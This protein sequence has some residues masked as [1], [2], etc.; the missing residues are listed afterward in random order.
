MEK[1]K[2]LRR[3]PAVHELV[4]ACSGEEEGYPAQLLAG[5]ARE[6]LAHWRKIVL[7]KGE[8]PPDLE[9]LAEA[10]RARIREKFRPSLRPVVNATGVVLHTN[11]G[12]APLSP[13]AIAALE[14]VARG[15]CNLEIELETGGRGS[16]Y[17]HVEKLLTALTGA[18]AALVVNNN[19]AAVL[20]AL[21]T[22]ARGREVVV[23]RGELIEIGGSF[24]I[25]EV[26]AQSGARLREVGTTNKT[27]PRDYER[28]IGPETALL[29]KV[30]PSNYRILGFTREVSRGEL[31][32]LGRRH[33]VPVLED[34]GSGVLVDLQ[35]YGLGFEPTVQAS[36]EAGVDVVTFS[37]DKLLGGPQGGILV[38]RARLLQ[39]MKENPLLRAL[40]VDKLTLAALEATLQAYLKGEAERA[41]P[42]L[43]KLMVSPAR[44]AARAAALKERLAGCLGEACE[45]EVRPGSSQVGGGA[46]PLT[47]LP[48]TLVV[49]RPKFISATTLAARLRRGDPPVLTRL[50]EDGVLVDPRTLSEEEEGLVAGAIRAALR[51]P[52]KD[53]CTS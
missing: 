12:R 24:R 50:Q 23:A 14:R 8:T 47:E 3:L 41:L 22:L 53:A 13:G 17:S 27:Y 9:D 35:Q 49:L 39:E 30:H 33:Q 43:Q 34:L 2:L 46:L 32:D 38:G 28:A 45:V 10:V 5:A 48:T 37:G 52:R 11:L 6:V 4:K 29:L 19:A 42:V 36:L 21:H 20:L 25:P 26:L 40:R 15:Y 31:V 1:G 18:E 51:E 16:R 44:L 7:E